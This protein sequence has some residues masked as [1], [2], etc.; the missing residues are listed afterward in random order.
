MNPQRALLR[1]GLRSAACCA[2]ATLLSACGFQLAGERPLP[3]ALSS[4]YVDV[5]DPYNVTVPPL[6]TAVQKRLASRGG[7]VKSRADEASA[8]LRLSDLHETRDTVAI[9]TDGKAVEYRLVIRV[10]Y[11]LDSGG[12]ALIPNDTLTV[13][14]N[15]SFNTQQILAKEGEQGKL[16]DYLEDEMAELLLLRLEAQLNA[17][18]AAARNPGAAT[19]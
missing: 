18:P 6:E 12:K 14:R 4:V 2:A 3:A 1:L 5:V 19:P 13:A 9:G 7:A 11:E 17:L 16:R 8:V 15:Y 10:S